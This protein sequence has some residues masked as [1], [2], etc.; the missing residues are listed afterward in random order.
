VVQ[1][2]VMAPGDVQGLKPGAVVHMMPPPGTPDAETTKCVHVDLTATDLPWRYTPQLASGLQ[3]RPWL[4]SLWERSTKSCCNLAAPSHWPR[5]CSQTTTSRGPLGGH[6]C[7]T[8][9][10]TPAN[11]W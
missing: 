10:P 2:D 4:A 11:E 3:L 8:T 6:T 7:R 5:A 9:R 1:F